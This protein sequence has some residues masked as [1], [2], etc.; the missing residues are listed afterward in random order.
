[1]NALTKSAA[2]GVACGLMIGVVLLVGGRVWRPATVAAQASVVPDVLRAQCFEM[3]DVAGKRRASL[4]MVSGSPGLDLYDAAG[5][6]RAS[7]A[8]NPNGSRVLALSDA[9]GNQRVC[10]GV[11]PDGSP[12]LR[13]YDAAEKPRLG[14]GVHSDGNPLL[15]LTDAAGKVIWAAP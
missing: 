1:M 6:L 15:A 11:N 9:A 3:V 10:L 7:L 14:L 13:L 8:G 4:R 2:L 5:K 12:A